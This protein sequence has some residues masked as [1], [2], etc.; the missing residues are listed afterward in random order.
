MSKRIN[1]IDLLSNTL[2]IGRTSL[3][4][5]FLGVTVRR[6]SI[7]G[8]DETVHRESFH[9]NRDC[10]MLMERLDQSTWISITSLPLDRDPTQI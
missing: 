9:L 3:F 10:P 8:S 5:L 4:I 7:Y 1:W 6:T 2:Q